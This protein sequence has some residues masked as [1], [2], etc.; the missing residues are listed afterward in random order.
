MHSTQEGGKLLIV[1]D[2]KD[3]LLALNA[4]LKGEGYDLIEAGSGLEAI[5]HIE[6]HDFIAILLDV[7]MP[8]LNG[9]QTAELIR[10]SKKNSNT[11]IIFLTAIYRTESYEKKGYDAGAVDYIFKPFNPDILRAK[12]SIFSK[13]HRQQKEIQMQAALV[14]ERSVREKEN[15]LL[16]ESLK[17]RDQFLSMASHELKTPITPLNLQMQAFLQMIKDGT[18]QAADPER[19]ERMLMTSYSQVERL[20]KTIDNLLD[21]SRFTTGQM[22]L[23]RGEVKLDDLVRKILSSFAE[24]LKS[25]GCEVRLE[26]QDSV[27]GFWD[28][29]RIEQVFINLLS[30]AM[31]YG[32]GKPI[33]VLV[34]EK[35]NKAELLVKDQGIGIAKEDQARIFKRFERAVS[36]QFYAGL[37]LG[38]FIA[39][40]IMRLHHGTIDV[41]SELGRGA[42]FI[43]RLPME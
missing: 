7:Q 24:Q 4:V 37:G 17:A 8:V 22:E 29:F 20:S 3:N 18:F 13:L 36:P 43:V 31:K 32:A 42:T 25:V 27:K 10:K 30:N 33:E 39:C 11:P 9:F 26:V 15:A 14:N 38:L 28:S 34:R 35:D 21:V 40:E 16:K 23:Q 6:N 12:I 1:D 5:S 19:L 41:E 2:K